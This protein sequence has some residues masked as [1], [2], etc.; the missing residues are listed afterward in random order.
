MNIAII[1]DNQF[2]LSMIENKIK[3]LVLSEYKIKCYHNA[4]EYKNDLL[5]NIAYD[6]VLLDIDLGEDSGITLANETNNL[7]PYTQIIYITSYINFISDVYETKH[8]YFIDK[9]QIDKYLPL[10]LDKAIRNIQNIKSQVLN[11]SWKKQEFQI[12]QKDIIYI[13][14]KRRITYIITQAFT[15]QTPHKINE[16]LLQLNDLFVHCHNSYVVNLKQIA[17][18]QRTDIILKNGTILPIS[19]SYAKGLKQAYNKFLVNEN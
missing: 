11:I 13:E 9:E 18:I 5:N 16:L 19:R 17:L 12:A 4:R 15:Y 10:A 6:I 1:E 2:H 3:K 8:I 7:F 14:R